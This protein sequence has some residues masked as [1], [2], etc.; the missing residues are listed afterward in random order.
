MSE[1]DNEILLAIFVQLSRILDALYV[2]AGPEQAK[3]LD[4]LHS[5]GGLLSSDPYLIAN[6]ENEDQ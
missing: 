5:S 2:I 3:K 1:P 4:E 6:E